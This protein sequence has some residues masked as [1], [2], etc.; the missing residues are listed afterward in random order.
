MYNPEEF[1][2]IL[3]LPGRRRR[4]GSLIIH[5]EKGS[6]SLSSVARPICAARS[7]PDAAPIALTSYSAGLLLCLQLH[8]QQLLLLSLRHHL[9]WSQVR[10]ARSGIVAP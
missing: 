6:L 4:P 5:S 3:Q 9:E 10:V 1:F 8:L 2:G 7:C